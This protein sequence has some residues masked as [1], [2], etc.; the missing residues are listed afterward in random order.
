[1]PP[2]ALANSCKKVILATGATER[3]IVFS[4]NDRPGIMLA[5]AARRYVNQY[6]VRP[7]KKS[8][9]FHK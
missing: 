7:G 5:S 1:M 9:H 4:N 6:A 3:P 2:T 8:R